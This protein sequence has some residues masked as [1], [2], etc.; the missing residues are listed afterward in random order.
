MQKIIGIE[1]KQGFYEGMAC[2]NVYFI[3]RSHRRRKGKGLKVE[4]IKTKVEMLTEILGKSS[5]VED[6]TNLVGHDVTFYFDSYK[7]VNFIRDVKETTAQ[8]GFPISK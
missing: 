5:S 4:I 8:N 1:V 7:N 6:A 2:H 3:A